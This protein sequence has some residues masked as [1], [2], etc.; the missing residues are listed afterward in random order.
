MEYSL[1]DLVKNAQ[2][3]NNTSLEIIIDKF[4]PTIKKFTRKLNYEEAETDLIIVFIK[5]V[6]FLDLDNFQNV[7]EG[8]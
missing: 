7:S 6:R 1:I 3:G 2:N 5:L 8:A 4:K